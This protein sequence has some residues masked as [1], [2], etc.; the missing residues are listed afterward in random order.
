MLKRPQF[1]VRRALDYLKS[2]EL[3]GRWYD[4]HFPTHGFKLTID[5]IRDKLQEHAP[6]VLDMPCRLEDIPSGSIRLSV[7]DCYFRFLGIVIDGTWYFDWLP[8]QE[9]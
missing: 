5:H 9:E 1:T 7:D 2:L 6:D 4:D 8:D 3:G